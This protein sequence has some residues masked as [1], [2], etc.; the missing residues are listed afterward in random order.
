MASPLALA[1]A[2]LR[3]RADVHAGARRRAGA[4]HPAG[5]AL[6]LQ[7]RRGGAAHVGRAGG[8]QRLSA[9]GALAAAAAHELGSPLGTIAVVAKEIARDLRPDSP[10]AADV[11]LL[12]SQS[13]RCRAIL[14]ELAARP[15]VRDAQILETMRL[16]DL[17]REVA[18]PH[19]RAGVR[20]EIEEHGAGDGAPPPAV[21]RRPELLHGLGTLLQNAFEFARSLVRVEIVWQETGV[22]LTIADDGPGFPSELLGRLGEPYLSGGDQG[23]GTG[24]HMG[25]GIFIADTLLARTGALVTLANR[26]GGG[27]AAVVRWDRASIDPTR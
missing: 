2:G 7:R 19:A 5:R 11:A 17:V 18:G 3:A 9:L 15:E 16:A 22:A 25:L 13:E 8:E 10:L 21:R 4:G 20:L 26:R 27:A 6:C 24:E 12:Q 1:G 23:R 14:A